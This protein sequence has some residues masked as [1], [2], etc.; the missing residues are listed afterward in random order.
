MG[1]QAPQRKGAAQHREEMATKTCPRMPPQG[2]CPILKLC[3]QTRSLHGEILALQTPTCH[4]GD[5]QGHWLNI[6]E[7]PFREGPGPK[8]TV[9]QPGCKAPS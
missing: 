6:R 2:P 1:T 3:P 4:H 5:S 9:G 7:G 8:V